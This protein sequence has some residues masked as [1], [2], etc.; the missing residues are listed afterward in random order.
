M[1]GEPPHEP[2]PRRRGL[3]ALIL[4][5][6]LIAAGIW[7]IWPLRS[8]AALQDCVMTGRTNCAPVTPVPAPP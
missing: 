1:E 3:A 5:L 4:V 8:T 7:L 6:V 2:D